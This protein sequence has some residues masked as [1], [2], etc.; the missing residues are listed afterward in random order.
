M[1]ELARKVM[2]MSD[3]GLDAE[4]ILSC[5]VGSSVYEIEFIIEQIKVFRGG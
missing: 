5:G 2:R 4:Q 1:T 3:N